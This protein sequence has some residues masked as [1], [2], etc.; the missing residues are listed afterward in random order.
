MKTEM[1]TIGNCA[2]EIMR[3][4]QNTAGRTGDRGGS[5]H[6]QR[7]PGV[8]A[9]TVRG[10]LS[11]G[12][13]AVLDRGDWE[14]FWARTWLCLFLPTGTFISP[15]FLSLKHMMA[16]CGRSKLIVQNQTLTHTESLEN[17][18]WWWRNLSIPALH[19]LFVLSTCAAKALC[20]SLLLVG[21]SAAHQA[22]AG[23]G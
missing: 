20:W 3:M 9:T 14:D 21:S 15:C 1:K 13:D 10:D 22:L 23:S 4:P 11:I 19:F 18:V 17:I 5:A 12:I 16:M 7:S 8:P 2:L 6:L